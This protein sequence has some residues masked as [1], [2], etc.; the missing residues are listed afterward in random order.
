M[1]LLY[2]STT[3]SFT[4]ILLGIIL[5]FS[6]LNLPPISCFQNETQTRCRDL[7]NCGEL[8]GIGYPFWGGDRR[9]ECGYPR[10]Q[11]DCENATTTK[12]K[13]NG[14]E[15]RVLELNPETQIIRISRNDLS[16]SFCQ[17]EFK[18]SSL[19]FGLFDFAGGG[20]VNLTFLYGCPALVLPVPN[21]FDCPVKGI[22]E[23]NG[24]VEFG[25]M[26]L[27]G[28]CHVSVVVPV[29]Y[30]SLANFSDVKEV[31]EQGFEV[32]FKVVEGGGACGECR[33]SGGGCGYDVARKQFVCFCPDESVAKSETCVAGAVAVAE[34]Y[35]PLA[36]TT[37][38]APAA[39][40]SGTGTHVQ[41]YLYF[42]FFLCFFF[43]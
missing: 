30:A 19:D 22:A 2:F 35:S 14:V 41:M 16:R 38:V 25:T 26:Q 43:F 42:S 40:E 28:M 6:I 13:M 11:L 5:P 36:S 7:F 3:K 12:I 33:S 34:N 37:V 39:S 1:K 23:R 9:E 18:N 27:P 29:S 24:Y 4:L 8:T 20:Y 21:Q 10:L 15:Y 32:R 17:H 31:V